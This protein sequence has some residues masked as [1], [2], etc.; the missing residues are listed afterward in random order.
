M[1]IFQNINETDA[2]ALMLLQ[3]GTVMYSCDPRPMRRIRSR[4]QPRLWIHG[5]IHD[6]HDYTIGNTRVIAN[7][8]GY[9][10]ELNP[11]FDPELVIEV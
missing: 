3:M 9:I 7:P 8:R 10:D 4:H 1:C 2:L 5:H 6:S 11:N